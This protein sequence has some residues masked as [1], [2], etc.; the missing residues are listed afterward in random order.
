MH[1]FEKNNGRLIVINKNSQ[2][3]ESVNQHNS[4]AIHNMVNV[5]LFQILIHSL[6]KRD[7]SKLNRHKLE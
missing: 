1:L 3:F 4:Q 6:F 2:I 5:V 7:N